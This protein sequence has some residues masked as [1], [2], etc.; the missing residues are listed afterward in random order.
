MKPNGDGTWT[1]VPAA[2]YIMET[3]TSAS[4]R[5]RKVGY[6]TLAEAIAAVKTGETVTL[7]ADN[8][9]DIELTK[10]ITLDLNRMYM[11]GKINLASADAQLTSAKDLN[12]VTTIADAEV[13]YE[14]GT[15]MVKYFQYV[16]QIGETQ[17]DDLSDAL[18]IAGESG[19]TVTVIAN[20]SEELVLVPA[21]VTLNLNGYVVTAGNVLSFG[22]VMD[23]ATDVGGIKISN[24]TTQ[25]FVKLQKE[26]GGY[27][28]M[29]DSRDGMYKFFAFVYENLSYKT[30]NDKVKFGVRI[31]FTNPAGYDVM[32]NLDAENAGIAFSSTIWWTGLKDDVNYV[33]SYTSDDIQKY[34]KAAID[35]PNAFTKAFAASVGGYTS[36]GAGS[37]V[38]SAFAITSVTGFAFEPDAEV[39][40]IH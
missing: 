22:V 14:N 20:T 25:A 27:M 36:L 23:G 4:S 18:E 29:Y 13:V 37:L 33:V 7:L 3:A 12:V 21:D 6:A 40:N 16:A 1:V 17:Y 10:S 5:E 38:S 8:A 31:K 30:E 34:A 15:Y 24:D 32:A 35:N 28:P 26:N 19:A 2:A 11:T 9:E 39:F